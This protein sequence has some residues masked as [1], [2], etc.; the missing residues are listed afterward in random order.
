M[1]SD[2]RRMAQATAAYWV[3]ESSSGSEDPHQARLVASKVKLTG[4]RQVEHIGHLELVAAIMSVMLA[5]KICIALGLPLDQVLF[6]TDSM[7]MLYWLTTTSP[8]SPYAGHRVAKI[9]ERTNWRQWKYVYTA[10]NPSDLPTRGLR[11]EDLQK[12]DLWMCGP[13]FLKKDTGEWPEK[14]NIR[15][16]EEAAAEERTLEEICKGI[17]MNQEG[18]TEWKVLEHIRTRKNHL[19]RQ[20]GILKSV[21][22]FLKKCL[23]NDR[24]EKTQGRWKK[25]S[26]DRIRKYDS[27]NY[28]ENFKKVRYVRYM[29]NCNPF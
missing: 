9:C 26:L 8:L 5:V 19:R 6:F 13:E 17:I 29:L 28:C 4:L 3:T 12:A 10:E 2:A 23:R 11:A 20:V 15:K 25:S 18:K 22:D 27:K 21:F 7:A 14:P 1:F 16:T 24:F